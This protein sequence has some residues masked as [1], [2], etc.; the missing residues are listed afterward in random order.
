MVIGA[1]EKDVHYV[2]ANWGKDYELPQTFDDSNEEIIQKSQ[3]QIDIMELVCAG[4]SGLTVSA[5]IEADGALPQIG[6]I[7]GCNV[8]ISFYECKGSDGKVLC[9]GDMPITV[10]YSSL[11]VRYATIF[12]KFIKNFFNNKKRLEINLV[13]NL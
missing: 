10:Y 4:E 11:D 7:I 2:G 5:D 12:I 9:R 13:L 1:N 8:D 3:K 6:E